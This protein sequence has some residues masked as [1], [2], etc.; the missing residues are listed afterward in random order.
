LFYSWPNNNSPNSLSY[1]PNSEVVKKIL[2]AAFVFIQLSVFAQKKYWQQEVNYTINVTLNDKDNTLDAFEKMVYVNNSPDT[3]QFI[4]FHLWPNAYKNDKT[5]FSEQMTANGNTDFYFS[6]EEDRGYI[7]RLDFKVDGVTAKFEEHPVNIDI[8]KLNLPIPLAPGKSVTIT[9]P[10]HEKLPKN[11]SRGGHTGQTYQVTQWYPKPAVYDSKGWHRMPYVDQGEFYSEFGKFDVTIT[12]PSNYIVAATGELQNADELEKLKTLGR[13]ALEAQDNFKLY[14]GG[15]E[16]GAKKAGKTHYEVMPASFAQTKTLRYIQEQVHDFAWFASKLFLVEY[17]TIQLSSKNVNAFTFFHPWEKDNWSK[18]ISYVKDGTRKYSEYIGEYPF[19]AVNA[20]SGDANENSGGMEYPTITLITTTEG[21]QEMDVTIAHEIGHNWFYGILASNE[22]DHP[23]MD[24]G[25]NTYYQ[26]R[27]ELEK[28]G[29][30]NIV[31]KNGGNLFRNKTPDDALE[32]L[33]N[34]MFKIYK[35][36]PIETPSELFTK[37]NYGLVVYIKTSIW[38]KKLEDQLGKANF[39]NAMKAYYKEWSFRHPYPENFKLSIEKTSGQNID[40]LY[41]QLSATGPI[42][43]PQKKSLRLTGFYNLKN[44][45]KYNYISLMPAVGYNMYDGFM[46]GA[47]IHNYEVPLPNFRFAISPLYGTNSNAL[48]GIGQVSYH[49]YSKGYISQVA[50]G[51]N[52]ARFSTNDGIDSNGNKVFSNF[53]K[54]VPSLQV[55]F[56]NKDARSAKRKWIDLRSFLINET[57]FNYVFSPIDNTSYPEKGERK[58]RYI[59]QLSYNSENNRVLYPY[60]YQLQVQQGK[61]FY[62]AAATLNYFFNYPKG[63]GVKMRVTAVK[64]GYIGGKTSLKQSNTYVYQPKL[65]AVRGN[66]DYTYSNYFIGR[67]EFEGFASQQIMERDGNLK[68]RTDI[69]QDLQGR[70]DDW[71]AAINLSTSIPKK[72]LPLPFPIKIY[73]DA[74]TYADAWKKDASVGRFLYVTG[75]Q[76]SLLGDLINIYAPILYSK[77]F[78][79]NLKTVPEEN[80]FFKKISFSINIQNLSLRR[81]VPELPL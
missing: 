61:E 55:Y 78:S 19:K 68:I 67:N 13:Q 48:N 71:I 33:L 76:L 31:T 56:N 11:F 40:E 17:D 12:L 45:G 27:Y 63:G 53:S 44:T 36:Q 50:V 79:N 57:G 39:D 52:G 2:L 41:N 73:A 5:A 23:W 21:G 8:G 20:V 18:S 66:E 42:T 72:I 9:T 10:F 70:S 16:A 24:E 32:M 54:L 47:M 81:L 22:R 80:Q 34:L 60:K 65:T 62:R 38:M 15:L 51:V 28:Y 37:A 30:Y 49:W 6:K 43:P 58:S 46:I 14:K 3:L 4:W 77:E 35:D 69:F 26:N 59:N 29:S 74:G 7:N 64:F 25:M 1:K 75:I